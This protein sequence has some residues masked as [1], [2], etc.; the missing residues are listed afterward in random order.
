MRVPGPYGPLDHGHSSAAVV[1][2]ALSQLRESAR[3][4]FYHLVGNRLSAK[5]RFIFVVQLVECILGDLQ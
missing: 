1:Q 3:P 4:P 2:A 5:H